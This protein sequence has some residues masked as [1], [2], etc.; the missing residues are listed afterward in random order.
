MLCC[1]MHLPRLHQSRA[2]LDGTVLSKQSGATVLFEDGYVL[3]YGD[4]VKCNEFEAM[5]LVSEQTNV[6]VPT[7]L[8]YFDPNPDLG[9]I[10][11]AFVPGQPLKNTW[12]E[13]PSH[14]QNSVITQL[15]GYAAEW[16]K[17]KQPAESCNNMSVCGIIGGPVS[18]EVPVPGRNFTGPFPDDH[19]F[20][21]TI[22]E[23]Y[24]LNNGRRRTPEEVTDS[25]PSSC[26][27]TVTCHREIFWSMVER[28][29]GS[30]TGN[31]LDGILITGNTRSYATMNGR[32]RYLHFSN[33]IQKVWLRS[34][35]Y[36]MYY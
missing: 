21:K 9:I 36:D 32:S 28:S 33:P 18:C 17:I 34:T 35:L 8:A 1:G 31:S 23:S 29:Q 19:T 30:L 26:S 15:K 10:S 5:K 13:M 3:K 16:R 22:G 4:R 7:P 20:R 11:M 6:P 12:T 27:V 14:T 25:L 2:P 24:Y